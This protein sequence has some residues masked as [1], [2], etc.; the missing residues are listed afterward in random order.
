MFILIVRLL[1]QGSQ[2]INA[3]PARRFQIARTHWKIGKVLWHFDCLITLDL[4]YLKRR[5]SLILVCKNLLPRQGFRSSRILEKTSGISTLRDYDWEKIRAYSGRNFAYYIPVVYL[6]RISKPQGGTDFL[7]SPSV[8]LI[9]DGKTSSVSFQCFYFSIL[10]FSRLYFS[11]SNPPGSEWG[12]GG[13]AVQ[14]E[15][16]RD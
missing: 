14:S 16:L 4:C 3:I 5:I 12:G 7:S 9:L 11:W 6:I 1:T 15:D 13:V 10:M 2:R 8:P